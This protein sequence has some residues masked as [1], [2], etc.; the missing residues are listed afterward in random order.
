EVLT[1]SLPI[2]QFP[3][4]NPR[5]IMSLAI[6]CGATSSD[7]VLLADDG[8]VRKHFRL[9]PAN[10]QLM[11]EEEVDN[12]F[13]VIQRLHSD[14]IHSIGVG[15]PGILDAA[16]V[17]SV[18][19]LIRKNWPELDGLWIGNDL[20]TSLACVD[21]DEFGIKVIVIAGTGSCTYGSDGMKTGKIGGYGHRIGDRGSAYAISEKALR[22]SLRQHEQNCSLTQ[23]I[24]GDE[25]HSKLLAA[26]L[27]RLGMKSLKQ[28]AV[29]TLSAKKNEIAELAPL[30][31]LMWKQKDEIAQIVIDES[32]KDLCSDC[33][34]LIDKLSTHPDRLNET[35][36]G[37]ISIGLTGSLFSKDSDFADNF[38]GKLSPQ[39]VQQ[40]ITFVSVKIL[41]NT[42]LGSLKMLDPIKWK[43]LPH[44]EPKLIETLP[45]TEMSEVKTRICCEKERQLAH[46]V[47][48]V[49]LG[50]SLT[51]K[52][53]PK[54]MNLDRMNVE[55]AIDLMIDE[56][57][58]IFQEISK[59]KKS[60]GILVERVC[61]AFQNGGRLFY[62]GAGTSGRLGIL[63]ATECPPTFRSPHEWVQGIIAGGFSSIGVAKEGAEDSI[64][65]GMQAIDDK[66]VNDKDVVVGIAACGRTP[67]VWGAILRAKSLGAFTSF[68]TFN[69]ELDL[70]VFPDEFICMDLGPEVLTGSTRL[71]CGTATKCILN[72]VSTLAMVKYGKCFENLMVDLNPANEKLRQRSLRIVLS[73]TNQS[74]EIDEEKSGIRFVKSVTDRQISFRMKLITKR[75]RIM[76]SAVALLCVF[77]FTTSTLA[78]IQLECVAQGSRDVASADV[79]IE[80]TNCGNGECVLLVDQKY[81]YTLTFTPVI[82]N[83]NNIQFQ[84]TIHGIM[85]GDQGFY[86]LGIMNAFP[87]CTDLEKSE[88]DS[89]C[90][91]KAQKAYQISGD[92]TLDKNAKDRGGD[93]LLSF[94]LTLFDERTA[95]TG[96]DS[97]QC[98]GLLHNFHNK[99]KLKTK[100][101]GKLIFSARVTSLFRY[102]HRNSLF[103]LDAKTQISFNRF[104]TRH[105][106]T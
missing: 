24:G 91:L 23:S 27:Q 43:Q 13:Q 42:A 60:I 55:D 100:L 65:D 58:S 99:I 48:P 11:D 18:E 14:P 39:L 59:K 76:K 71:K 49:P 29:W 103:V 106:V 62:V 12:F 75:H 4:K 83:L 92:F 44:L 56:E 30:V 38:T 79:A 95:G 85:V 40:G 10:Y 46:S 78:S 7:V 52:R 50:L 82:P 73:M 89:N 9:G 88:P 72:M 86:G 32:V 19:K 87:K 74:K 17:Q 53:N 105:I 51:E 54:S 90:S 35:T 84:G 25:A 2:V 20:D 102:A 97:D 31:L 70:K 101:Y 36:N 6:E 64:L 8:A 66:N 63:D 21:G 57:Q 81:N 15:M 98:F 3:V 93:K 45:N 1:K 77:A 47:L 96:A 94:L 5:V 41:Q 16:D 80:G 26:I 37:R 28:L 34:R 67:F 22:L 33:L 68:L 61:Q 69:T 104:N